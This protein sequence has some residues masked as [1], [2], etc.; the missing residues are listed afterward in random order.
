MFFYAFYSS[1][2]EKRNNHIKQ[3]GSEKKTKTYLTKFLLKTS[4]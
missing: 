1:L 3:K 2:K 4:F